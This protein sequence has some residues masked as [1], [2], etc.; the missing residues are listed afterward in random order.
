MHKRNLLLT[1]LMG[2]VMII[3]PVGCGG[4]DDDDNKI[5]V[6]LPQM[7]A[8]FS[9]SGGDIPVPNDL[10]FNGSIDLTINIPVVDPNNFS[11]PLVALNGLD[12]WSAVAPFS[13]SF[14]DFGTGL[15]LDPNSVVGG[16]SVRVYKVNTNRPEVAPG[17][18][19][20]TGPVTGVERELVAGTEYVVQAT[21]GTSIAIIPT[22]PFVQ[23]AG[24]MVVLTN[25]LL[26]SN[27]NP[28]TTDLEYEAS[29]SPVAI[30][31]SSSLAGLEP[32]RQLIY[33]MESAAEAEGVN[34][35][36]IILSLQFTVQSVGTVM[37]TAKAA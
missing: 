34:R 26:D 29:K 14:K 2:A 35:S 12:G 10:L 23:Q 15:T 19:A 22:V 24:Y 33:A 16:S 4:G 8:T 13:V 5:P 25:D 3:G 20:P 36:G 11:D 30:S 9:P 37:N 27:G 21:S 17:I 18:L 32:V 28:V 6:V 1:A 31:P 7:A